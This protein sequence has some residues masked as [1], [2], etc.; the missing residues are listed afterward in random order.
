MDHARFFFFAFGFKNLMTTV[1]QLQFLRLSGVLICFLCAV[2]KLYLY[3][4]LHLE[5][6]F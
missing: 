1:S 6:E 3:L 2:L 4:T 5:S